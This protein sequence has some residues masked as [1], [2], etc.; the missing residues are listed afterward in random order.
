MDDE[1]ERPRILVVEDDPSFG[2]LLVEA[3]GDLGAPRLVSRVAD[4]KHALERERID[5]VI[6]DLR[7]SDVREDGLALHRWIRDRRPELR[8]R[9]LLI[10]GLEPEAP[11]PCP[12]LLKP[13]PFEELVARVRALLGKTP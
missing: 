7:F 12:M 13:F 9:F 10:T 6:S 2:A 5:C 1:R 3:L 4:A 11:P 8:A